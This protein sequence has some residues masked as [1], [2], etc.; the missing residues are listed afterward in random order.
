MESAALGLTC[1]EALVVFS[2]NE[3]LRLQARVQELENEM[4]VIKKQY[5]K[6]LERIE[7]AADVMCE[8]GIR[9]GCDYDYCETCDNDPES[10]TCPIRTCRCEECIEQEEQYCYRQRDA[11]LMPYWY[12]P[13]GQVPVCFGECSARGSEV[14]EPP[15]CGFEFCDPKWYITHNILR[16]TSHHKTIDI[17]TPELLSK[18]QKKYVCPSNT[19]HLRRA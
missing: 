13:D 4:K 18:F 7:W 12:H 3:T 11:K 9:C 14:A 17:T 6:Q 15:Y 8:N 5:L 2:Q 1:K 16:T 10:C 19:G